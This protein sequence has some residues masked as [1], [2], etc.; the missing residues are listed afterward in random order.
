MYCSKETEPDP[1][2]LEKASVQAMLPALLCTLNPVTQLEA[3]RRVGA[4]VL[5]LLLDVVGAG[6]LELLLDVV[7]AGVLELP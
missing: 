6:V 4:G 7:G 3:S 5:E 1:R 2:R